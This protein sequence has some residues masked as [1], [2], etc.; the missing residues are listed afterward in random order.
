MKILFVYPKFPDTFW[1]FKHVLHFS[2]YKSGYPPL[3]V[4]TVAAMLPKKWEKKLIDLNFEE[5]K[6]EDIL[7]AD[8]VFISAMIAQKVSTLEVVKR[9]RCLGAKIVAGGPLF[10]SSLE[11]LTDVSH[12]ILGEAEMTLYLFLEDLEKGT[13]KKNYVSDVLPSLADTP[14]P[15]WSLINMNN[16]ATMP[17]QISRGCPFD[18]E[19]CDIVARNGRVPRLKT[20]SQMLNELQALY[21][22][23]WQGGVFIVDDNFIGN[24]KVIKTDL[25]PA[26]IN[27]QR[28]HNFPFKFLTEASI[29]L[30]DDKKLLELMA[31]A[32]FHKVFV[33]IETVNPASL[34]ECNKIHNTKRDLSRDI[35]TIQSHGMQVMGGFI[36]GFD[37]D[38]SETFHDLVSFIQENGIVTAMVGMLMALP[39]TRLWD[40]LALEGRLL[41]EASGDNTD[42]YLNLTPVMGHNALIDGYKRMLTELY[43]KPKNYYGRLRKFLRVYKPTVRGK[44]TPRDMLAFFKSLWIIG[45]KS[46]NRFLFWKTFVYTLVKNVKA[47]PMM[48]ELAV[49]EL[50][51]RQV[52]YD[53]IENLNYE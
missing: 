6:D 17:I 46:K 43:L 53:V 33:G 41:G 50:H 23:G 4:L 30:A 22:Y 2:D 19:F 27:W 49:H 5:L 26:L 40:R 15:E 51:F 42:S 28:G 12:I 34:E 29:N 18:C 35:T 24:K 9:C 47:M 21:D 11:G 8:Y 39:K 7:W 3:G 1:S 38:T 25:L 20:Q 10:D 14:V 44:P 16:Y 32:N 36:I 45:A 52:A 13:L 31:E 37:H 48:I